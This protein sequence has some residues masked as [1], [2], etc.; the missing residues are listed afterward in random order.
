[1]KLSYLNAFPAALIVFGLSL[2][3]IANA[4]PLSLNDLPV[5]INGSTGGNVSS[6]CG[7]IPATPDLEMNLDQ[8]S[9]LDVSVD[10]AA[11]A[12]I[13]IDGPSDF[14]VL[15]DANTNQLHTAGHWPEGLY[16]IYVGDRQG[17]SL[18]FSLT[19]S[20]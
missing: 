18:P 5:T 1:M 2:T 3:P 7:T 6:S 9:Y 14:C 15:R 10:T 20:K 19:I 11:D 4:V 8:A 12:T 17:T 16:K 13:W